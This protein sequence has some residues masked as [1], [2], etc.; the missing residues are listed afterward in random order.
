MGYC[1]FE[2]GIS[3]DPAEVKAVN[4]F[5]HPKDLRYVRYFLGLAS[6]Y[7]CFIFQ[8]SLV[9]KVVAKDG[10][11]TIEERE[12]AEVGVVQGAVL[13]GVATLIRTIPLWEG[14]SPFN[15]IGG[16]PS[17]GWRSVNSNLATL[18]SNISGLLDFSLSD[19]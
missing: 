1:V 7:R 2:H 6:Y 9:G 3:A 15:G 11:A 4:D 8:K 13:W 5:P 17:E 19:A 16:I 12:R 10:A 14:G 18:A